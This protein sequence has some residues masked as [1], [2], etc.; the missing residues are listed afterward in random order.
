MRIEHWLYTIPLRLRSLFRGRRVDAEL[1]EELRD[2][3]ERL[4]SANTARGLTPDDARDAARRTMR[5]IEARKDECRDARRI[6]LI[7]DAVRDLRYAVRLIGR[8]P[9]FTTVA[10]LSLAVGIGANAAIFSAVDSLVLQTLPVRDPQQLVNFRNDYPP[11]SNPNYL[12]QYWAFERYRERADVF[13]GVSA[14]ALLDRFGVRVTASTDAVDEGHARVALVSGNYFAM[15]G[16]SAALGRTLIDDDDR[17]PGDHPV[18]VISHDYWTRRLARAPD[19][20]TRRVTIQGTTFSI[21]GVGASGFSGDWIGR[22]V[23]IWAPMAMASQVVVERPGTITNRA[24]RTPWTRLVGRLRPGISPAQAQA[25][26]Q[27]ALQGLLSEWKDEE[28]QRVILEPAAR[29]YSPAR[30][31]QAQALAVLAVIAGLVF[32]VASAN[33]A[34]LLLARSAARQRE[35][36]VRLAIGATRGRLLRQLLTE[37]LLLS[38]MGGALGLLFAAWGTNVLA[39]QVATG[40][41][42]LDPRAASAL[43]F[44]LQLSRLALVFTA[45]LSLV[46][47]ML[48]GLAPAWRGANASIAPALTMRTAGTGEVRAARLGIGGTLVVAQIALSLVVTI[49]AGL[50]A[51]SLRNLESQELGFERDHIL[52]VWTQPGVTG[53]QPAELRAFWHHVQQRIEALTGVA[54]ASAMNGGVLN[55]VD[56][57]SVP[58]PL[59]VQGGAPQTRALPGGRS[60]VTPGFFKTMGIPLIAGRD[61]TERDTETAPRVAII[62]ESMA[63]HYFGDQHP[64]GRRVGFGWDEG[65]PTE[66]VGVVKDFTIGTPRQNAKKMELPFLSY[67]DRESG[68][69]IAVMCVAVRASGDPRALATEVRKELRDIDPTLPVLKIDTVGEQLD[70]VL[71]QDR[72]LAALAGVFG[73]VAVLLACLGLYGLIAYTVARRTNEIGIRLTLGATREQVIVAVVGNSLRLVG[74]GVVIGLPMSLAAARVIAARLFGVGTADPLTIAGAAVVMM[75]VAV[76]AA[77][78]P[79]WRASRIDPMSALRCE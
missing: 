73:L 17:R 31:T 2:H 20:L 71:A 34:S 63:R 44:D 18:V 39:A 13:S 32:L 14:I 33:V 8:G 30:T 23:D 58:T 57:I 61:F 43:S 49:G 72:L 28:R 70:D 38:A 77:F 68:R 15:L 51:R 59:R 60:F 48:F 54:S 6:G 55:G 10:V 9:G 50:L 37:S 40:P 67:R 4:T 12:H 21:V 42:T 24:D 35:T 11:P 26:A 78:V 56:L 47:G 36:A 64:V 53:R 16:V 74:A 1:D 66:I 5:G 45:G 3:I 41:V 69:R 29:G 75:I 62:N 22:P 79:A 7:D 65:T 19:V 27:S 76:T 25:A 52:L 46:T